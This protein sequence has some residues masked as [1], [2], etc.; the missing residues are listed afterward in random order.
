MS[1]VTQQVKDRLGIAD[2]VTS[3][4]K[5][6]KSGKNLKARCPFH[7]EKSASF[8]V[9]PERETYYCFGCGEHG[10]IFTFVEKIE[11]WVD[12]MGAPQHLQ[13]AQVLR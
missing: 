12:F 4:I 5:L 11:K 10:D 9:S 1:N 7:N 3:Y 13:H 2:V 8:Y 6:E